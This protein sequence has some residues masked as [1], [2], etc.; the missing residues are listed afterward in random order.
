MVAPAD[1]QHPE[2]PQETRLRFTV[3]SS[4][5]L[6]YEVAMT[7]QEQPEEEH[8]HDFY[9]WICRCGAEK[10][11]LPEPS[12][13]QEQWM[14]ELRKHLERYPYKARPEIKGFSWWH[15]YEA[16]FV[17]SFL[18]T[19]IEAA[20]KRGRRT[21]ILLERLPAEID[22]HSLRI[23]KLPKGG[24]E[25]KY[26]KRV[27]GQKHPKVLVLAHGDTLIEALERITMLLET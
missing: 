2:V 27:Q 3:H 19:Q 24:Y 25:A 17:E 18:T 12:H 9:A 11:R 23:W 13:P 7:P 5:Y 21:E 22:G 20:E 26:R 6:P 16:E 14:E 15:G 1:Q 4:V 8:K 10:P